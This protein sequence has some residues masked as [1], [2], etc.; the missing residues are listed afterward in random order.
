MKFELMIIGTG[1]DPHTESVTIEA[2]NYEEA[3][4]II[5]KMDVE[6]RKGSVLLLKEK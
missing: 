2:E 4:K 5:D 6:I 1:E 3:G